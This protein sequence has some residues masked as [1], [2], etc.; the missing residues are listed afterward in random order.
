[1]I[2]VRHGIIYRILHS[3][4][5][6]DVYKDLLESIVPLVFNGRG[7]RRLCYNKMAHLPIS[8]PMCSD[9]LMNTWQDVVLDEAV[10]VPGLTGYQTCPSMTFGSIDCIVILDQKTNRELTV[11]LVSIL[12]SLSMLTIKQSF[13]SFSND[14]SYVRRRMVDILNSCFDRY[15]SD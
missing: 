13:D 6:G 7:N 15:Q 4:V 10:L 12:D 5:T 2:S 11:G 8:L 1:M 3:I 14:A 9:T